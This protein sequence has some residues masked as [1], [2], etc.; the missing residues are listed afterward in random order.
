MKPRPPYLTH[1]STQGNTSEHKMY[2][3]GGE[4]SQ[5]T[6]TKVERG[7][8]KLRGKILELELELVSE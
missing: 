6:R 5:K 3:V 1:F 2:R 8:M 4:N 7:Q